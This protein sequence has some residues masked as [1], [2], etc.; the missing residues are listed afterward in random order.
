M[1]KHIFETSIIIFFKKGSIYIYIYIL[2]V[3]YGQYSNNKCKTIQGKKDLPGEAAA[4]GKVEEYNWLLLMKDVPAHCSRWSHVC[5]LLSLLVSDAVTDETGNGDPLAGRYFSSVS[6]VVGREGWLLLILLLWLR[7]GVASLGSI[8]AV[9]EG[10]GC[11]GG[12]N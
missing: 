1:R 6:H 3:A 11:G 2:C 10:Y 5:R 8:T 12:Y 9:D 4:G 7:K